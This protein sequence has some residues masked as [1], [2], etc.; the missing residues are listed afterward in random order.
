MKKLI[1]VALIVVVVVMMLQAS[2][3]GAF[4]SVDK[5]ASVGNSQ[6]VTAPASGQSIQ[7]LICASSRLV[8]C[9]TPN[10]GWN[11]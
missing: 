7:I 6:Y 11:S 2:V 10:V 3:G 9:Y 8:G 1:Q 4:I 5:M